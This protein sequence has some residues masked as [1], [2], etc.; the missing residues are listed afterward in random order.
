MKQ[1]SWT[2]MDDYICSR[3]AR[4]DLALNVALEASVRAG[5]PPVNVPP[6]QGKFLYLLAK[7][8]G[9]RRILEIGTLGGYSTIWLARALPADGVVISI[10][11][12]TEH[13]AVA[14][15]NIQFAKLSHKVSIIIGR[16]VETLENLIEEKA[17]PFDF[18]FIDADKANYPLYLHMVLALSRAGTVIVCDNIVRDGRVGDFTCNASDVTGIRQY[19]DLVAGM[20]RVEST[21][22][23]TVGSRGWDGF[24]I[25]LVTA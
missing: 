18:V 19:I 11:A 24:C 21:A 23:Q 1:E 3:L 16:A 8:R 17:E 5:L 20:P 25:S 15:K 13:A 6:N 10:E 14:R 4:E 7:I 9:A 2:E 22:L 12:K